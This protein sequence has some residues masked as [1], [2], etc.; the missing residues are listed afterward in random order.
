VQTF[1]VFTDDNNPHGEREFGAFDL[2]GQRLVWKM[3]YYDSDIRYS[4]NDLSDPGV[5]SRVRTADSKSKGPI[6]RPVGVV[7]VMLEFGEIAVQRCGDE[8]Q[9]PGIVGPWQGRGPCECVKAA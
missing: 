7:G 5:T 4:S 2:A 1:S 8:R 9:A 6:H 3:D